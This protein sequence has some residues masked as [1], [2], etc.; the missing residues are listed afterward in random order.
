MFLE[1]GGTSYPA[2]LE[3]HE[4]GVRAIP[5]S[6]ELHRRKTAY[7]EIFRHRDMTP[8]KLPALTEAAEEILKRNPYFS[9]NPDLADENVMTCSELAHFLLKNA[10][11]VGHRFRQQRY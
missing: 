1:R 3:T 6:A 8:D 10:G 9:F 11:P 4:A 7:V 5:L 2:V